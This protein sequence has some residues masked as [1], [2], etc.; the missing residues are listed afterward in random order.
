MRKID[1]SQVSEKVCG[2]CRS[3]KPLSEFS[4]AN[5]DGHLRPH[6]YCRPCVSLS[7][8]EYRKRRLKDDPTLLPQREWC[9]GLMTKYGISSAEY[10]AILWSQDCMCAICHDSFLDVSPVVDH[11]H[12]TGQVR[13]LL[14]SLCNWG[15]GH[16][17]D[18]F[19]NLSAAAGYVKQFTEQPGCSSMPLLK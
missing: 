3:K 7:V 12:A 16:F 8:R 15:L 17:R 19:A 9:G 1:W 13:G 10:F 6:G 4:V 11:C 18:S 5:R 2:R 14:C